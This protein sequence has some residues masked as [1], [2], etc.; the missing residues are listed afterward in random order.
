E[1]QVI[2]ALTGLGW[3]EKDAKNTL[4]KLAK[5]SPEIVETGNVPEILRA[6]LRSMSTGAR[7][8]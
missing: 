8:R 3:T 1:P 2:E 6:A 4:G 5:A 7:A